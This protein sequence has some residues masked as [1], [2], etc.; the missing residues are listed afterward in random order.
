MNNSC[1][2]KTITVIKMGR[3]FL[4][5]F[6]MFFLSARECTIKQILVNSE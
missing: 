2:S 3:Y 5:F 1:N 6:K 4:S